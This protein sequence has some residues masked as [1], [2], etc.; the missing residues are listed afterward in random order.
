MHKLHGPALAALLTATLLAATPS[1]WGGQAGTGSKLDP[2]EVQAVVDR[3]VAYLKT[4]QKKD[5]SFSPKIA[6]PGVTALVVASLVRNGVSPGDPLVARAI[7]YLEKQVQKDGGIYSK[8]LA[9]YTT[10]VAVMAFHEANADGKYDTVIKNATAFL[11][12]LQFGDNADVKAGG[13]G[14]DA[15]KRPDLS[16]TQFFVDAL[17]AAGVPRDDPAVQKALKFVSRCQNLPGEYNDQPFAKK[18]TPDDKG[19]FTYTPLDPDD[20]PHKTAAGGLRSLGSM[21]Y[22]GLKSFLYAGVDKTDPRVKAAIDWIRR[23]YTLEENP[24]MGQAGLYYYYHTFG[25]AMA[26]L[27]EDRFADAA[28]KQHDWRRDLFTAL[29]KRQRSDGSWSNETDRQFGERDPDL[30]TAFALLTLSYCRTNT[31]R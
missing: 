20:S 27:G 29:Q 12:G 3:A 2:Q 15:T 21:T 18:T 13:V 30:A 5:G 10:S 24:G 25:K 9:N 26:A 31:K 11:K 4:T 6:G 23:H 17:L 28:G 14:Y 1:S 16:N 8:G 22:G 19:G 7:A